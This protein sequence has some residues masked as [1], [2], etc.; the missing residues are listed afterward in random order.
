WGSRAG[1]MAAHELGVPWERLVLVA[2][3]DDR[4][5]WATVASVVVDAFDVV[6][7]VHP[8]VGATGTTAR[9]LAAR[10][11]ERGTVVIV[12]E[13]P[14]QRLSGHLAPEVALRV[15]D[16]RW[17]GVGRGHGRL[18]ARRVVVEASGRGRLV[19]PRRATL[20][21]PAPDGGVRLADETPPATFGDGPVSPVLGEAG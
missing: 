7:V 16:G 12:V 10:A 19:R 3:P 17:E 21:L 5:G 4:R 6:V 1:L 9:R 20:W 18:R 11:R 8:G 13:G 14:D 2:A 15:V